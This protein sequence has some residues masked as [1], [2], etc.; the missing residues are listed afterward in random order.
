MADQSTS[1]Q[2]VLTLLETYLETV[3]KFS[4]TSIPFA[5]KVKRGVFERERG[6][7]GDED[8]DESDDYDSEGD[9]LP[10]DPRQQ[11]VINVAMPPKSAVDA[12]RQLC[13]IRAMLRDHKRIGASGSTGGLAHWH[14]RLVES[15]SDSVL[16]HIQSRINEQNEKLRESWGDDFEKNALGPV[17]M[18]WKAFRDALEDL[19]A[20]ASHSPDAADSFEAADNSTHHP[21]KRHGGVD[22]WECGSEFPRRSNPLHGE[23]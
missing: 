15:F 17:K 5:K 6:S 22:L 23:H 18:A 2:E 20:E 4:K 16:Q 3:S 19:R 8:A 12:L 11:L 13:N 10:T 7:D 1:P 14:G 9:M 21:Q